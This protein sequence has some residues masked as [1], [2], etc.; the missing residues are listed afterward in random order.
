M[1]MVVRAKRVV[2][3]KVFMVYEVRRTVVASMLVAGDLRRLSVSGKEVEDW[4]VS[5]YLTFSYILT[6]AE[7][8]IHIQRLSL[9]R[10]IGYFQERRLS[11]VSFRQLDKTIHSPLQLCLSDTSQQSLL[12]NFSW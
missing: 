12:M 4:K 5:L 2:I 7:A 10:V 9:C 11:G 6:P 3:V 1:V 8:F